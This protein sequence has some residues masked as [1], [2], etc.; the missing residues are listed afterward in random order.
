MR[1]KRKAEGFN[2]AFL[3]IMACG[4]GA[5]VL[6]FML[7]KYHVVDTTA[8]EAERLKA[9]VI[10]LEMESQELAQTLEKLLD[11][12]QADADK[13]AAL[14]AKIARL[15]QSLKQKNLSLSTKREQLAALKTDIKNK[16][17]AKKEDVVE[18]DRGGE[19]NY[20]MGLK[21]Q[22]QRILILVD[23]SASMTDE[24]L[25]DI[26]RRKNGT[27]AVKKAGP[28]WQR[29]RSTVRWLLARVP[30]SSRVAVVV[31][32]ETVNTLGDGYFDARNPDLLNKVYRQVDELTPTGGTNLEKGLKKVKLMSPTD[33]Y[34][35]TDGLPTKGDSRYAGLNPFANCSSLLGRS[36][37]IS[38]ECR[39]KLFR[40]TIKD[41][42][43]G[44]ATVNVI[45]FPIEGDP[46]AA[47]EFWIWAAT[48]GGMVI[49]PALNWP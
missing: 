20:L 23:A 33:L 47:N 1:R 4:L 28:K 38:G 40:K 36:D 22:G 11:V 9:D 46:D 2:L 8:P 27:T 16:P 24:K 30:K 39:V 42:S 10:R 45:L 35:I 26:I 13:I 31:F 49:S 48:S 17:I 18:D 6:V 21:V 32:N 15:E 14:K 25:I 41:N 37:T 7:V 19:E 34:L 5:V 12:S 29:T 44:G 43:P 3:D